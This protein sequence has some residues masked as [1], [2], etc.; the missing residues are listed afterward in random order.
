MIPADARKELED[1][2]DECI[3]VFRA[4][5]DALIDLN[6]GDLIGFKEILNTIDE[7]VEHLVETA[8]DARTAMAEDN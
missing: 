7:E 2:L 1:R 8:N 5:K 4:N 3:E 6:A